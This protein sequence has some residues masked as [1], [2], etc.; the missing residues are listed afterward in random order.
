M[1]DTEDCESR[2]TEEMRTG[3]EEAMATLFIRFRPRLERIIQLRL[4]ARIARR[5]SAVDVLQETYLRAAQRLEHFALQPELSAFMW[6]RLL[7]YQQISEIYRRHFRAGIRDIRREMPSAN[8]ADS[9]ADSFIGAASQLLSQGA[10]PSETLSRKE[11]M[12]RLEN[13]LHELRPIYRDIILLRHFE[14][15]TNAEA[16]TALNIDK[17]T[18][19]KRYI[20]AIRKIRD[21]VHSESDDT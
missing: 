14:E 6:I 10:T 16:A 12:V 19:R 17:S 1:S 18:A 21:Q 15:L 13:I 5:V 2:L 7:V 20:R 11:S 3:S 9:N 8:W 4:D